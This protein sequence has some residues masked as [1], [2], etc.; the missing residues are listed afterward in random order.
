[1]LAAVIAPELIVGFAARQFF[2][3]WWYSKGAHYA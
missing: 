2:A 1:M 3:A